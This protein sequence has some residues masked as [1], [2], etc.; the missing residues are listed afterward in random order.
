VLDEVRVPSPEAAEG[1]GRLRQRALG[2][3]ATHL[4]PR[5]TRWAGAARQPP[6][7]ESY[8][9]FARGLDQFLAYPS[10]WE[11]ALGS[12]I[13]S[14]EGDSLFTVPLL[15][16][17]HVA[18]R[19]PAGLGV[20]D[21]IAEVLESR[22]P[23]L[24]S[25]EQ[26][27]LTALT[28]EGDPLARYRAYQELLR[29]TPH[30]EW[31]F[32]TGIAA[33]GLNR[34]GEAARLFRSIDPPSGWMR[35]SPFHGYWL[36]RALHV[37]GEHE[38]ELWEARRWL[39]RFPTHGNARAAVPMALI[40]LGRAEEGMRF[41]DSLVEAVGPERALTPLGWVVA[42]LRAH[43]HETEGQALAERVVKLHEEAGV[44]ATGPRHREYGIALRRAGRLAE[45]R[46]ILSGVV[47][48]N[49]GDGRARRELALAAAGLGDDLE[50]RELMDRLGPAQIAAVLAEMGEEEAALRHLR[51]AW[52]E[53]LT[54]HLMTE[55]A[56]L[57]T[58]R[59][60]QELARPKG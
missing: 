41:V 50:A 9:H 23:R 38:A 46:E 43:G 51:E 60:F 27:F 8:R 10:D 58:S 53:P 4:D 14:A 36:T 21:S 48:E 30:S 37:G 22:R 6:S 33:L 40:G 32:Y 59:A 17:L 5:L 42:D 11:A 2:A 16:A 7:L 28:S 39:A 55:L 56:P 25:W 3:L 29:I 47:V 1:I 49:P 45:A 57:H 26:T 24:T 44:P 34:P 35:D 19:T 12:F 31:V 13:R 52:I 18:S 54:L 15:W 20:R